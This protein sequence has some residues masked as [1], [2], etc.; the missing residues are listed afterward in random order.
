MIDEIKVAAVQMPAR[1]VVF[2]PQAK[3]E[4]TKRIVSYIQS[5]GKD[6][7]LVIFPELITCCGVASVSTG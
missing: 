4:N 5:L 1:Q 2:D 6:N 3:G 7:D